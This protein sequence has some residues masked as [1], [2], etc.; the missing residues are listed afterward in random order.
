MTP[1]ARITTALTT[2]LTLASISSALTLDSLGNVTDWGI[3]PFS[4]SNGVVINGNLTSIIQNNVSPIYYPYGVGY[5]PSGGET[6]DIEEMHIR[7]VG[8]TVQVLIVSSMFTDGTYYLGDLLLNVDSDPQFDMGV[9]VRDRNGLVAGGLYD[10]ITTLGL[11]AGSNSY[12]GYTSVEQQICN[13]PGQ[14]AACLI[15]SGTLLSSYPIQTA[16]FN[17]GLVAG[18]NENNTHLLELTFD[19]PLSIRNFDL[20]L[21]LTC[22]NDVIRG[23][24]STPESVIPP[25]PEPASAALSFLAL[26]AVG[27]F[28][29]RRSPSAV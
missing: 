9:S 11:Q 22:G 5:A 2:L 6:Y 14:L 10:N 12:R 29:T 3:R 26:A 13:A 21:S 16:T 24:Y 8:T 25:I 23:S 19:L 28:V 17:Y 4:Q 18:K 7:R 15:G 27:S 1:L 20:Q